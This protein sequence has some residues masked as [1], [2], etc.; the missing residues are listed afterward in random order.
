MAG[1]GQI[2]V[3]IGGWTYEPW[4]SN[5]YPAGLPH[6]R[7]LAHAASHVTAIEINGTYY[8]LQSR[9]SFARW[10]SETPDDFMFTVKASRHCTN[11]RL[12]A[13]AG[14]SVGRFIGQGLAA[15]GAKLGPILWQFM[16]TKQFDRDDFAGFLALLPEREEGIALRHALEVRHES[17][18]TPE[19]VAMA[20]EAGA[21]IVFADSPDYPAIA[22]PTADFVYARLQDAQAEEPT[23]YPPAALDRWAGVAREWAA[24]G[25]P[26]DLRYLTDTPAETSSREVFVFFI[27]GAKERAPAAAEALIA[28]L[29][30]S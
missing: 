9:D 20:R 29:G 3:G 21:S 25:R 18:A 12:L 1:A 16:A 26:P 7:E 15:L 8:R 5:F 13:E 6:A 4:R 28:R 23:G 19:F 24:G 22:D 17:F 27:N 10:A 14:E 30:G 11:R 2:R